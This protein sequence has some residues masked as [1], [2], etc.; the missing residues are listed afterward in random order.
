MNWSQWVSL[1]V[2]LLQVVFLEGVL[3][4]DNAAVL[5]AV[6]LSLPDGV[7]VPWPRVLRKVGRVLHPLLG[8]QR[9]AALRV[10]LLGAYVGRGLMLLMASF[11]IQNPWLQ[12]VGAAYLIKISVSELGILDSSDEEDEEIAHQR[13]RGFWATVVMVELMDLAFSL[14]NVVVAVSLSPMLWVV[15]LGVAIGMITMRFAA[16]L[17]S[18]LITKIPSLGPAAYV[19]VFSIAIQLLAARLAGIEMTNL[20]RFTI[21][22]G[23][24]VLAAIYDKVPWFQRWVKPALRVSRYFFFGLD[25]VISWIFMPFGWIFKQI[26]NLGSH[27]FRNLASEASQEGD[28]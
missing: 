7:D 1:I 22:V 16:S 18:K 26:R 9:S 5:G 15:M 14:D 28:S 23:I 21:N 11:I 6:V 3:S 2:I 24:L 17:F 27:L 19:L 25:K 12:L 10:G 4:L 13:E 20:S 8:D